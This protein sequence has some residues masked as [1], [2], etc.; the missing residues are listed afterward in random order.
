MNRTEIESVFRSLARSQGMY[1]RILRQITPEGY[2]YLEK[3]S[4]ED[5]LDLVLFLEQ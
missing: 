2:D 5:P 4:F 1:G 3:Q